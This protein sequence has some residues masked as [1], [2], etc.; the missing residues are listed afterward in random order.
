MTR[1]TL[2]ATAAL[3]CG[4]CASQPSTDRPTVER[5]EVQRPADVEPA[6]LAEMRDTLGAQRAIA[7]ERDNALNVRPNTLQT[8]AP[9]QG[10]LDS[11]YSVLDKALRLL[12]F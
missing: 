6:G 10:F 5:S 3:L 11:T 12:G 4:A 8:D 9:S 2:L 7:R 1:A